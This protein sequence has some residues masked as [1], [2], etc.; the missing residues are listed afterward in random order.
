MIS[1][2]WRGR[3]RRS[4]R[5]DLRPV[6]IRT[7]ERITHRYS[8][9]GEDARSHEYAFRKGEAMQQTIIQN[10]EVCSELEIR[11]ISVAYGS[12]GATRDQGSRPARIFVAQS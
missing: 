6:K 11:F 1:T 8:H 5:I 10:V 4:F 7:I 3:L 2:P 9:P 12:G